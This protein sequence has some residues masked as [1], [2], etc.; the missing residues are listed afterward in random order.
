MTLYRLSGEQGG[1]FICASS[2]CLAVWHPVSTSAA[3][4][5]SAGVA[6]L[7]T[8]RRPDGTEQVTYK[9]MPLYTFTGDQQAGEA[10][11]QGLKDVGTWSAA[12]VSAST[13]T[14]GTQSTSPPT[15]TST[16]GGY[17]Y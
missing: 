1:K 15:T 14:T 4:T 12:T 10:K 2:S 8:V 11:G 7:G 5:P 16:S 6:S 9:G 13:G 3:G 17:R